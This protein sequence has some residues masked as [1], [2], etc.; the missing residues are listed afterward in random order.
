M[1]YLS[2]FTKPKS[3]LLTQKN[4]RYHTSHTLRYRDGGSELVLTLFKV[5]CRQQ[6]NSFIKSNK[7]LTGERGAFP[8]S[9]ITSKKHVYRCPN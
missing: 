8:A 5:S 7:Y 1:I 9:N 4:L 3:F 2:V 6:S